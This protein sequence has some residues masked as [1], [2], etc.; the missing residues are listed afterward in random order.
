MKSLF[1]FIIIVIASTIN[2]FATDVTISNTTIPGIQPQGLGIPRPLSGI[3]ATNGSTAIS[4]TNCFEGKTI[5]I[6][7]FTINIV[8]IGHNADYSDVTITSTSSAILGIPYEG[9][10]GT[11][12]G[13]FYPYILLR[14]YATAAFQPKDS[15][16]LIQP[17]AV[18]ST[19]FFR[20][21]AAS[22]IGSTAYITTMIIP[23]TTNA[24]LSNQ[25]RWVLGMYL[26][27]GTPLSIMICPSQ[28]TQWAIPANTPTTLAA[29][30]NYNYIGAIVPPNN[31][32]YTKPQIDLRFPSCSINQGI[33]YKVPGN[34]QQCLSFGGGL[35]INDG[36]LTSTGEFL[37]YTTIQKD[38]A[39][40]TKR[41]ILNFIG[42]GFTA[43]NDVPNLR[44][45]IG[46][47]VELLAI[48]NT[49]GAGF[50]ARTGVG[51]GA[52]RTLIAPAQGLGINNSNGQLG[53]PTFLLLN[54]LAS[55]EGLTTT[56]IVTR[57]ATDTI[58]TRTIQSSSADLIVTNGDGVAGNPSL[59][60]PANFAKVGTGAANQIAYFSAA[61]EIS[62]SSTFTRTSYGGL[63]VAPQVASNIVAF[64]TDIP[65]ATGLNASGLAEFAIAPT[66]NSVLAASMAQQHVAAI[67]PRTYT[68]ASALTISDASTLYIGGPPAVAG[69]AVITRPYSFWV[70]AGTA[71]FDGDL[72]G[73]TGDT[74][75]NLSGVAY[76]DF[77]LGTSGTIGLA[78]VI[79]ASALAT[80]DVYFQAG[81]DTT[82]GYGVFEAVNAGAVVLGTAANAAPVL[83]MVNRS[84]VGR[85]QENGV[86][87]MRANQTTGT[88]YIGVS[89]TVFSANLN[90]GIPSSGGDTVTTTLYVIPA[91]LLS[92][93]GDWLEIHLA[94]R[95]TPTAGSMR[96]SFSGVAATGTVSLGAGAAPGYWMCEGFFRR[97]S[98]TSISLSGY[99]I[100]GDSSTSGTSGTFS[101]P[102]G[103]REIVVTVNLAATSYNLDLV[104]NLVS[105]N[106]IIVDRMQVIKHAAP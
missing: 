72:T 41:Q 26:S 49:G 103:Y 90:I 14:W 4:C 7:G 100:L 25:A 67:L 70:D 81:P 50:W 12:T 58:V 84:E 95:F 6:S 61:N 71:R 78:R 76:A 91:N 16:Y 22:V 20:Q 82:A 23:A 65:A 43:S 94:G 46:M 66:G 27:N 51:T 54:D 11:Y 10:T 86:W 97:D 85:I 73:S 35:S 106:T 87:R 55:F 9:D 88:P 80:R 68:A 48:A 29:I 69:S 15:T 34:T 40:L 47:N 104:S 52:Y 28:V 96:L 92:R 99:F 37:A 59:S 19:G 98:N 42:N 32:S 31:E 44:T 1:L 74:R 13:T 8:G 24:T 62:S 17:G 39:A 38:G 30:C 57:T 83:F 64:R 53:N 102:F 18:G 75:L 77:F 63:Q 21:Y 33:Y 2:I 3:V 5:G 89:G 60:I 36:I 56:G 45:N 105:A 79:Q 93:D 101:A